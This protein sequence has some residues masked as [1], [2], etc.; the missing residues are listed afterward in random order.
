M[1][2]YV[3][4]IIGILTHG[5]DEDLRAKPLLVSSSLLAARR[6]ERSSRLQRIRWIQW[7]PMVR[8][9]LWYAHREPAMVLDILCGFHVVCEPRM[10]TE[11]FESWATATIFH[12]F[13]ASFL[14]HIQR[15]ASHAAD[16]GRRDQSLRASDFCQLPG[17]IWSAS[18]KQ[19]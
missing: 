13:P 8:T 5:D 15:C 7:N 12:R 14:W 19:G 6:G 9:A 16:D 4:L 10:N 2:S 1:Y 18:M 11:T 3:L 17:G